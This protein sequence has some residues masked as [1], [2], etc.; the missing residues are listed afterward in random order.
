M[1]KKLTGPFGFWTFPVLNALVSIL[2]NQSTVSNQ[3]TEST[4]NKKKE[5]EHTTP[6]AITNEESWNWVDYKGNKREIIVHRKVKSS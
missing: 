4:D 6:Q 5:E 2:S 3:S 1:P